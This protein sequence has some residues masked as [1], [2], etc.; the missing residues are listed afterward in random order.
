MTFVTHCFEILSVPHRTTV[1]DWNDMVYLDGKTVTSTIT[2][3]LL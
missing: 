1:L 3:G 2:K